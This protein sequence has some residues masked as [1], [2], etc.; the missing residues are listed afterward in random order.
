MPTCHNQD[1]SFLAQQPS[2][3]LLLVLS[4]LSTISNQHRTR[5]ICS[6]RTWCRFFIFSPLALDNNNNRDHINRYH[7]WSVSILIDSCFSKSSWECKIWALISINLLTKQCYHQNKAVSNIIKYS[8]CPLKGYD[9]HLQTC[10]MKQKII[11]ETYQLHLC[12][13]NFNSSLRNILKKIYAKFCQ[14]DT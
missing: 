4:H 6:S 12:F 10:R 11:N 3:K 2:L 9:K 7:K 1:T 13:F 5:A 14:W 8:Q